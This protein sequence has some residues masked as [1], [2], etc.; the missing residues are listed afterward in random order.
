MRSSQDVVEVESK[1]YGNGFHGHRRR[2][3]KRVV[4]SNILYGTGARH[5]CVLIESDHVVQMRGKNVNIVWVGKV[6]GLFHTRTDGDSESIAFVR[7][8]DVTPAKDD[9]TSILVC[10]SLNWA[11]EGM[12]NEWF[13]IVPVASLTGVVPV[14][15]IHYHIRGFQPEKA[16]HEKI[17]YISRFF[18]ASAEIIY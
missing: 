8:F 6:L 12:R 10:V 7:Y 11:R 5:D 15:T 17:Y 18:V 1:R 16:D 9:V 14:V 13:D 3:S 4:S 2:V